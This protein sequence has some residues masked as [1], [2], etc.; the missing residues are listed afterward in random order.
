[1][2]GVVV[3]A[4][5]RRRRARRGPGERAAPARARVW[6]AE[7]ETARARFLAGEARLARAGFARGPSETLVE[8]ARRLKLTPPE[9]WPV[10]ID[11]PEALS[12]TLAYADLRFSRQAEPGA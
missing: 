1:M 6:S 11:R 2:I 10:Q 8:Y 4:G 5:M 9:R 3:L 7:V 12:A